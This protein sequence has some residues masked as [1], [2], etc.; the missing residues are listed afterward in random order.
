MGMTMGTML[1]MKP[2]V[3]IT[4]QFTNYSIGIIC[5]KCGSFVNID[6]LISGEAKREMVYPDSDFTVE[7]W[8]T[9]CSECNHED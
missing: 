8:E 5:N 3:M 2:V 4:K 9:L 1:D 6:S 7:E